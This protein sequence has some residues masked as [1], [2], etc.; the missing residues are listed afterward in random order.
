MTL[1]DPKPT[2]NLP[3][4]IT[5]VEGKASV[6][7]YMT[8]QDRHVTDVKGYPKTAHVDLWSKYVPRR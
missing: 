8:S 4:H 5:D 1:S 3:R 6:V 7:L 2:P